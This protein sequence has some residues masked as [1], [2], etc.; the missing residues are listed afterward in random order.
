[1]AQ[2][3]PN[4][5]LA[6]LVYTAGFEYDPTQDTLYSRMDA[7][8]RN[9]GYAYGYDKYAT[10]ANFNIDCEPIFFEYK[11]KIWMIELWK[12]QYVLET[13][14]E[15]GIYNRDPTDQ[16]FSYSVMDHLVGTR[17]NDTNPNHSLFFNCVTDDEMLTISY[18]LY[19]D[20]EKLLTRGPEKHWWLTGFK[21]GVYSD[22]AQ[23][24]MDITIAFNDFEM[25]DAVQAALNAMGYKLTSVEA[26]DNGG[27]ITF[28][29]DTPKSYQPRLHDPSIPAVNTR[30]QSIVN[31][32]QSQHFPNN[33]PNQIQAALI[34]PLQLGL[35]G[36]LKTPALQILDNL[37][38][39]LDDWEKVI[40]GI[41]GRERD[42]VGGFSCAVE[43]DNQS[44]HV[45]LVLV[46]AEAQ[47]G[48]FLAPPPA[49][50][51]TNSQGRLFIMED[52][53]NNAKGT[54]DYNILYMSNGT[55]VPLKINFGCDFFANQFTIE[56][57]LPASPKITY[58]AKIWNGVWETTVPQGA[59]PLIVRVLIID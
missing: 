6:K 10:L 30:N 26:N 17:E 53:G 2:W 36:M 47:N 7:F 48:K 24:K 52:G 13:G 49:L 18:T 42:V 20:G 11:G 4:S 41:M 35:D 39:S 37:V 21:W 32:Y 43:F 27:S 51:S 56:S 58:T 40:A 29:F 8:Q 3:T 55:T 44:S 15:I 16:S 25:N 46:D 45:S 54:A 14:C 19:R 38:N 1:M 34:E 5:E 31:L 22:P 59:H 50:I 12:G 57:P 33:D 28:T 23:L 9:L